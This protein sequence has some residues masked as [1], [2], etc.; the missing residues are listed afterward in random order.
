MMYVHSMPSPLGDLGV[1]YGDI[2]ERIGNVK[3]IR[4]VGRANGAN[5]IPI[6]VPVIG[7]SARMAH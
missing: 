4:A 1:T 5:P 3:A 7:S 6:I 2:A